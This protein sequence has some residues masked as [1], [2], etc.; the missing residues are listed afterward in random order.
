MTNLRFR[1]LLGRRAFCATLLAMSL[2][3]AA[4]CSH[5]PPSD[6]GPDPRF[7]PI[8]IHV[9]NENFL[10]AIV[11]VVVSGVSR[12]LGMVTGNS[13]GDFTVPWSLGSTS[14]ITLAVHPI[15]GRSGFT[16]PTVNVGV[17]QIV[18]LEIGSVL[19]HSTVT[20]REP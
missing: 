5:N 20:V 17:G 13:A 4:A 8:P 6:D 3:G 7:D 18:D 10:D 12:R 14:G 11:Y 15:G 1:R 9:R 2:T 16:L 19:I